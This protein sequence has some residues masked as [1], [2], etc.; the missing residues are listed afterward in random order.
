MT[1]EIGKW[2]NGFDLGLYESY[3][4]ANGFDDLEFLVSFEHDLCAKAS[5]TQC[6]KAFYNGDVERICISWTTFI[7]DNRFILRSIEQIL[8]WAK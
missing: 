1:S 4:L 8:A 2:L 6:S 3:L 7:Q 5:I